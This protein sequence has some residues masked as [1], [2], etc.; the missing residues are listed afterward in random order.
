MGAAAGSRA[1]VADDAAGEADQ[2]RRRGREPWPVRHVPIG[3][4][5]RAPEPVS[6]NPPADR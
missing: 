5:R 1:L 3:R 6:G 4:S 2:E